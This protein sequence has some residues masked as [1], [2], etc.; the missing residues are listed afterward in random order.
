MHRTGVNHSVRE[1]Q[2]F[3][4]SAIP[5]KDANPALRARHHQ[6]AHHQVADIS[7]R[8]CTH[9]QA[10]GTTFDGAVANGDTLG[11][12]RHTFHRITLHNDAFSATAKLQTAH[13]HPR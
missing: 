9:P 1:L 10:H 8:T 7:M 5:R 2:V 6:V 12:R 13:V 4:R 3:Y 11:W